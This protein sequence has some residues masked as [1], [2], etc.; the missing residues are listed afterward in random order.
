MAVNYN[1][2]DPNLAKTPEKVYE[3]LK[4]VRSACPVFRMQN[5]F[6]FLSKYDDAY[7]AITNFRTY[8]SKIGPRINPDEKEVDEDAR[9][10]VM[11]DPP[12][13]KKLR[14]I[15]ITSLNAHS[16]KNAE[17]YIRNLAKTLME[18]VVSKGKADL[19]VELCT[20][21]PSRVFCHVSGVPEED[22]E[23]FGRWA[24]EIVALSA[25]RGVATADIYLMEEDMPEPLANMNEY[26]YKL[27]NERRNSENPPD[28]IINR[29]VSYR[30]ENG[31]PLPDK[32]IMTQI[33]FLLFAGQETTRSLLQNMLYQLI[34]NP[35]LYKQVQQDR[36]LI[37][38]AVE[39]TLRF[40]SPVRVL[41]RQTA[42]DVEVRG[43]QLPKGEKILVGLSSANRD[44]SAYENADQF[45]LDRN[46][47]EPP[48]IAF[49]WG[50]HLCIGADLAR[51]EAAIFLEE[52]LN[53]FPE[54]SLDPDAVPEKGRSFWQNGYKS[55]K[56]VF[57]VRV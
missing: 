43:T 45:R 20:P 42:K 52:F 3:A 24:D 36:S 4:E 18:S 49:G 41:F 34:N 54:I 32:L 35:K 2:L 7:D 15:L 6:T 10:I 38:A 19:A 9:L 1:P 13:H 17:G 53:Y 5:G 30:D 14:N 11:F 23:M 22:A 48:H 27:M 8:S 37:P 29:L 46:K 47:K 57:P 26:C 40:D 33:K 12:E 25:E 39:E 28:D 21:L 44:E 56:A 55:L 50:S 51:L 31:N 16:Y